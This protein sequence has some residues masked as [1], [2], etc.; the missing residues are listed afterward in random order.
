MPATA[1]S[2]TYK[3]VM[4]AIV[5]FDEATKR[6]I[7]ARLKK[8]VSTD[9]LTVDQFIANLRDRRFRKGL[10]CPHCHNEKIIRYGK[11]RGRQNYW[12][13]QCKRKFSDHTHTPFRG[14]HYPER[15]LP[16][17]EH[18]INGYSIRKSAKILGMADST[19]FTWRHKVL[20]GL[21]RMEP[22]D[23]EG[24]LEVDETYFRF[25]RKG[26]KNIIGRKPRKRGT[27]AKK[28]GISREQVCVVVA[29]DRNKLTH[30]RVACLGAVSKAKAHILLD[31]YIKNVSALCSDA[32][33]TWKALASEVKIDH[34]ELNLSQ[35]RRVIQGI[36]HV[37][38][39]NSFHAHLKDW[40]ARFKGVASKFL[41]NYLVWYRFINAHGLEAMTAK[42]LE[43]LI[44]A[45]LPISPER[46]FEIR[47][48]RFVL[49]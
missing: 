37:Q 6:K 5:G 24:L 18:M 13:D 38:N 10:A 22:G 14:T 35:N 47:N 27:P 48:T 8:L 21:A 43:L 41:D 15:W 3:D 7:L 25:S 39:V 32:N 36:Y 19:V 29:R 11:Q 46:Y 31:P 42:K 9:T 16:F 4:A 34:K 49:P 44:L 17:M 23:F 40:M 12:C 20:G 1:G 30:A 33:G 28:R 26:D 2:P 45:C